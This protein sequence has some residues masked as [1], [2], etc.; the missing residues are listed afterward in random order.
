[1]SDE[2]WPQRKRIAAKRA[3]EIV[4]Y[5]FSKLDFIRT[6]ATSKNQI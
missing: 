3:V 6:I 5:I 1:M 4:R 2:E